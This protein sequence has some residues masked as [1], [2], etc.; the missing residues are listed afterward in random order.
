MWKPHKGAQ[1][2]FHQADAFEV[3][4]GGAAGGGKTDSLLCEV[5]RQIHKPGYKAILFRRTYPELEMSLIERAYDY[6]PS[7]G[8]IPKNKGRLWYF[9][10][11]VKG[12]PAKI[13]FAHLEHDKDVHKYQ[14]AEFD[15]MGFDE[16]TSFTEYQYTYMRSRVRGK[17]PDIQRYI[18]LATNPGNIGHTWFKT[19]FIDDK[20]P[21]KKYHFKLV[22]GE[23]IECLSDDPDALSRVFIPAKVWDNP[24]LLK[25]NPGYV[26]QL[27]SLDETNRR[28]LLEGDWDVFAGQ[29]FREWRN[30]RHVV[31][32]F[33]IPKW[34]K[35]F[36]GIDYGATAPFCVLWIA[37]DDSGNVYVYREYYEENNTAAVNARD[38]WLLNGDDQYNFAAVDPSIFA[39]THVGENIS[40]VLIRHGWK[41][42]VPASN[43]RIAGWNSLREY[44]CP[45]KK[46][47]DLEIGEKPDRRPNLF[48]FNNCVNLI[49]TLPQMI[50]DQH[51]VEDLN[52][53]LEDHAV[54]A[55][56]YI[57][58]TLRDKKSY[59]PENRLVKRL[60]ELTQPKHF[61]PNEYY[62]HK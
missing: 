47:A 34:W 7:H 22:D 33:E 31:E 2:S 44:I 26:A 46:D 19:R 48:V 32:P 3:G 45:K 14:S 60:R 13:F 41:N 6:Y 1:E 4:Y 61:N 8:G 49:R 56:R 52:T 51:K 18:M 62:V 59:K 11:G 27:K 37:I 40:E 10:T 15:V 21:F 36:V 20:E 29:Y 57:I 38:S 58:Q 25:N 55:L 42:I 39:K 23:D 50:H 53:T 12:K 5:L 35:R 30:H 9:N 16:A 43:Q 54:D 28:M 24:T 17:S